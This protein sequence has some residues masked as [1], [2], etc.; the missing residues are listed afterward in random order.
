MAERSRPRPGKRH[1]QTIG[2]IELSA[3]HTS[4]SCIESALPVLPSTLVV[5][6]QGKSNRA[7]EGEVHWGIE[8]QEQTDMRLRDLWARRQSQDAMRS[9]EL[10]EFERQI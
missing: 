2:T 4:E 5:N 1:H 9:E 8:V 3:L 7:K 10:Y 6:D